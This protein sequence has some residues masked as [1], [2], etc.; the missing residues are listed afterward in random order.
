MGHVPR[1]GPVC[2]DWHADPEYWSGLGKRL[3]EVVRRYAAGHPLEPGMPVEAARHELGL[4]ERRLV[5]ALVR[6]P[7]SLAEGRIVTGRSGLPAPVAR[8][9]E[10]LG[11]DLAARPFQAP[12]ADRLAVLGLGP[13]EVAAAVRAG[14]LLRV[15]EGIVLLPG[16]DALAA[17]VLARL[18]Q[19]FTVS[20]ARQALGT[21]RR[22]AVPLL[23]HLDR[24]GLTERIDGV[25]RR[26][27]TS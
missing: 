21:S 22:V 15:A 16:A 20:Q 6:P 12:E 18:P 24:R 7:L 17:R 5:A 26:C 10:R 25:L 19:P 11:A 14:A 8:A 9:V 4:P 1:T 13:R 27:R 23:E 2:A 3:P